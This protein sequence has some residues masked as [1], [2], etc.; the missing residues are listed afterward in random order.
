[1][2]LFKFHSQ[3]AKGSTSLS[4]LMGTMLGNIVDVSLS[5][6]NGTLT[7]GKMARS[8]NHLLDLANTSAAATEE[9][10]ATAISIAENA[11]SAASYV[12]DASNNVSTAVE[13][14]ESISMDMA[15]AESRI[16]TLERASGEIEQVVSAIDEI[17]GQ[18]NLLAL[19]AA[20]EAARAG[21]AGKG[22]AV[23]AE[24]VKK[25]STRSQDATAQ[26]VDTIKQIQS[27]IKDAVEAVLA[28]S[29]KLG[30][31]VESVKTTKDNMFQINSSMEQISEATREQ[32]TATG[33]ISQSVQEVLDEARNNNN[34]ADSIWTIFDEL[35]ALVEQQRA[36]LAE[37]NIPN[38]VLYLA[39]AD[40]ALWKK[41]IMDFEAGRIQL[42]EEDAGD[43]TLCRLGK[44]Y[45]DQGIK[46]LQDNATFK[47][48]E[49]P[50]K[51]VHEMA[52]KA[53]RERNANPQANVSSYIEALNEASDEVVAHLDKLITS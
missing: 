15:N 39:K 48:I 2:K 28:S 19:N 5:S 35:V 49:E 53:V 52:K 43:H 50:H 3:K 6:V 13:H 24:E 4:A 45:Y 30:Q 11:S 9:M 20:I 14:M 51:R 33:Q 38:K 16:R 36:I 46:T 26:I 23:V 47:A 25:L 10:S 22:F 34:M 41:K 8:S 18:T 17:A 21:D 27:D 29:E 31:G 32:Q 42:K 1:M 12:H 37:Q 44:W 40:H 7:G